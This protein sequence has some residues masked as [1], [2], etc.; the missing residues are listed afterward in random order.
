M[1]GLGSLPL[2]GGAS[3]PARTAILQIHPSLR[4][5][6]SCAHC[7]SS[8]GPAVRAELDAF[9]ICRVISDAA[10]MGYR[11]VSVS[12]GEPLM[13]SA[14]DKVLGHAKSLD[15]LTTVTTNGFFTS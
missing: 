9:T 8:S 3:G 15:M 10:A 12:G 13:Y 5:N 2:P 7:Y 11:V 14:L 4:C 6:L 1:S